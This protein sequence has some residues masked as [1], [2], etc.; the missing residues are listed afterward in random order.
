MTLVFEKT[1][2]YPGKKIK[3]S[4][5]LESLLDNLQQIIQL[6]AKTD[7]IRDKRPA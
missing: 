2:K 6:I 4:W 3:E 7:D 1:F 5:N